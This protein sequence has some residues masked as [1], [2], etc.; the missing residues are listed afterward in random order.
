MAAISSDYYNQIKMLCARIITMKWLLTPIQFDPIQYFDSSIHTIDH[1]AQTYLLKADS[2]VQDMI[3]IKTLSDGNCLYHSIVYLNRSKAVTASELR[4]LFQNEEQYRERLQYVV[5]LF[6]EAIRGVSINGTYSELYE[7]VALSNILK[8]NIRSIYPR[9]QYRSD[10]DTMKTTFNFNQDGSLSNTIRIFWTNTRNEIE[11]RRDNGD[12]WSPNHFVPLLLPSGS[13]ETW[14]QAMYCANSSPTHIEKERAA[15]QERMTLKRSI[16][17]PELIERERAATRK[18]MALKRATPTPEEI[19]K[20]RETERERMASK[21]TAATPE[22]L[23]KRRVT[24]RER[25]ASKRTSATPEQIEKRRETER[26]RISRKRKI[27]A[28]AGPTHQSLSNLHQTVAILGAKNSNLLLLSP[29][30]NENLNGEAINQDC[31]KGDSLN[32]IQQLEISKQKRNKYL[33]GEWPKPVSTDLKI[34]CLKD[35]MKHMSMTFL[36]EKICGICNT[37][38]YKRDLHCVP[39]HKIPF[40]HVLKPH[41]DLNDV[42]AKIQQAD[43]RVTCSSLKLPFIYENNAFFYQRGLQHGLNNDRRQTTRCNIC[44]EC[45]S[46]LVKEKIPK[47][48]PANKVWLGD[49][50]EELK[51]LTILE[52]RLIS[53]YRYNSCIVKLQSSFHSMETAQSALRGNC[54][55]FPQ[56]VVNIAESLPLTLDELCESLKIIFIGTQ[57][58]EKIRVKSILTVRKKNVLNALQWLRQ[59]NP[60]YRNIIVNSSNMNQLPDD[61]IPE[62]LW[63]TMEI[64]NNIELADQERANYIPDPLQDAQKSMDNTSVPLATSAVLD[65]NGVSVSCDDVTKCLLEKIR[66]ETKDKTVST[67]AIEQHDEDT[68]YMIPRGHKP[69][70]EY[71][72]PELLMGMFPT[73][74]PYGCGALEDSSR[75]VK[76]S[77]LEHIRYL[78][79]LEDRRFEKNDSFIFIVFNMMQR[80]TACFHAQLMTTRPYFQQSAQ[81]LETL[82]SNDVATALMNISKQANLTVADPRVNVLMKHIKAVGGR[83]MGSAQSRSA[84]RTKIHALCFYQ[85]L[86]SLFVTINPADIHNPVALYFAGVD[87]NLDNILTDD[88]RTS[89]ERAHII[90]THPVAA[91]KFFNIL[92]KNILK[93]LV[94]GGILGPTSAYFGTVESQ[95]RGSLHLHLLIWLAHDFTPTQLKEKIQD[96]EFRAK[97]L[98]YIEDVVKEDLDLFQ[99]KTNNQSTEATAVATN[100]SVQETMHVNPATLP[101]PNPDSTN[102]V[103]MFH[104]YVRKLVETVNV[105]KHSA[106]CYKYSKAKS[107]TT[108]KCR[109]RMPRALVAASNI[110]PSTGEIV[111]KRSHQWINNFNEWLITAC[112]SNMDIKFIWSGSDA[113]ALVYYITDYVTKSSLSFYDMFSLAQQGMKSIEQRETKSFSENIIEKSRKLVLRC[114]NMIASHQEVSGVQVA[115]YLMN[116]GDHYTTHTFQNLFLIAIEN[117]LQMELNKAKCSIQLVETGNLNELLETLH[118]DEQQ[119]VTETGEEFIL[120]PIKDGKEYVLVNTR[121]DYQYRSKDLNEI[122]LYEFVSNYHKRI[123][124][125]SDRRILKDISANEGIQLNTKGTKMNERHTFEH[126][127]PQSSSH[128]LIKRSTPVVPVLLGPQVPRHDREETRERYHRALLTM[129]IPWRTVID[130]CHGNDTWSD[131]FEARKSLV[132][133]Q[134][135]KIIQNMQLFHE[136]KKQ[137]D[138]HLL[139]VISQDQTDDVIDPI[140]FPNGP[141]DV[142]DDNEDCNGNELLQM[143]SISNENTIKTSSATLNTREQRYIDEALHSIDSTDRFPMINHKRIGK[144]AYHEAL[145]DP[146]TFKE[147]TSRLAT[148]NKQWK[149]AIETKKEKARAFLI[150]GEDQ[151]LDSE[152]EVENEII[153]IIQSTQQISKQPKVISSVTTTKMSILTIQ[154]DIVNEYTL[155]KEQKLA[156]M[157]ITGHLNGESRFRIGLLY[158]YSSINQFYLDII[159]IDNE[160]NQLLMCV[161]GCGGTG[162]SQLIRAITRYFEVT[163]RLKMLR[164]NNKIPKKYR[165]KTFRPGD[166]KLETQWRDV[167]YI[168]IDEMSMVGLSLFA[169]L[170]RVVQTAKHFRSDEAFGG[171]NVIF[172][173]DFLQYSPVLDKPLYANLEISRIRMERD[174]EIQCAQ[175]IMS[176]INC[177][178]ELTQQ[179]R[180]EDKQ[181]LGLL[182]RLRK[183]QSTMEDCQLLCTRVVGKDCLQESL[184][185]PPWDEV[186][187]EKLLF[188]NYKGISY[189]HSCLQPVVCV[190]QDDTG[191]KLIENSRLRKAILGLPDNETEHLPGYLPL[192][193]GIPVLLT[194]NIAT[195]LGLSNGVRG[196]FHQLIYD[197][198]SDTHDFNDEI[199]PANTKLITQPKYALVEFPNCKLESALDTLT[200]KMIPIPVSEQTF[201]FDVSEY[202]PK[203]ASKALKGRKASTNITV[204]RKALPLVPAYSIT[205]HKSQGQTLPKIIVD[206]VTPPGTVAL[207]SIYVPLSRVKRLQDLLIFRPFELDVLQKK[208]SKSQ[209]EE[210]KRLDMIVKKNSPA[211]LLTR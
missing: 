82:T 102:F 134:A 151:T 165:S 121:L 148:M 171:V 22:Q 52:Q 62:C 195:E 127:H 137:R 15:A 69:A 117:Y 189:R 93:C 38:C 85:G 191:R 159:F 120:E 207:A 153:P 203:S 211:I 169:R 59:N 2:D 206:L 193:P 42:I 113:K 143:L 180:T 104:E 84:L 41:D 178:V 77:L 101:I 185:K 63:A 111:M 76:I 130:L 48:S 88:M 75:P 19:E 60:L 50:P 28:A 158:T 157:I 10:L 87:L 152:S 94:L 106:T 114:Y 57:L 8:C 145:V 210:R 164:E 155:N 172:F 199:F 147:C 146:N 14:N 161:P 179:M 54:I 133:L 17:T 177:A 103:Q 18:R 7:I 74:F 3:P 167:E 200:P 68:V 98:S 187:S 209:L 20:R 183:G 99:D 53:L 107:D 79:S 34:K 21:R 27:L 24:S 35:F 65:V 46:C 83:V 91:A 40:V 125:G 31:D 6:P 124:D 45:W 100:D 33:K 140:L 55:S 163:K 156:F 86:P 131:A 23:E 109:M 39:L 58:P 132:S 186:C 67:E 1:Q 116:Y 129:F 80:R 108:K 32:S 126:A 70:N 154:M 141:T 66:M 205:T 201:S 71:L 29:V 188:L 44:R 26:E 49:I 198:S 174:I 110:D 47:F 72:N 115:S 78:L 36:E 73:L 89:Y 97:L 9:I 208:P 184:S 119:E 92:I 138:E 37:R 176:Q 118:Q 166:N 136:C 81:T 190:A 149:H 204:K 122:C 25:M 162:K 160:D 64:S 181:Y 13:T 142:D 168:I 51:N 56:N 170:N 16:A 95:G 194:E 197:N 112:R 30:D 12:S 61:D 182:N 11:V 43:N 150:T 202:L 173:G 128:I 5:G 90:A 139:Q 196:I 175:K 105:H 123:I 192:I 96:S 4:K 144:A 135:Q